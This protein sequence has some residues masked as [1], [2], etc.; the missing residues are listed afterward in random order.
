M[1]SCCLFRST[2]FCNAMIA[3]K[4]EQNMAVCKDWPLW[5]QRYNR[6]MGMLWACIDSGN[7]NALFL[8]GLVRN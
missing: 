7:N 4:V 6:L 5:S 1:H 2:V 3:K 8:L